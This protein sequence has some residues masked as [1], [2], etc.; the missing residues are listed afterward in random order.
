M[1]A[2][3]IHASDTYVDAEGGALFT[4]RWQPEHPGVDAPAILLFHDSLGCVELWRGF[5]EALAAA[6]GLTVIAYDRLGFGRSDLHPGRL[7][8]DFM[9]DEARTS[10]PAL[11]EQ[12]KI[13]RFI[14]FGHSVG[15]GMAVTVAAA[16]PDAC[17]AVITESAQAFTEDR[18]LA[19]IRNA[20]RQFA[21]PAQMAR[22]ARYHGDKAQWVLDAWVKTWQTPAFETWTLDQNLARVRCPLLAMHGDRDEFGSDAHPKRIA[23]LSGGPAITAYFENCGHVPHR[24]YPELVLDAVSRFLANAGASAKILA[25]A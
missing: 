24:E 5:P 14:A 7:G 25:D 4:R 6:T 2:S 23:E 11:R 18:T 8:P 21:D 9:A 17:S 16:F 19:G 10:V 1:S 12:F 15:G 22:L 3:N 13:G 20:E